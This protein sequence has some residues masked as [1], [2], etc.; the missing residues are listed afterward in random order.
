MAGGSLRYLQPTEPAP[1]VPLG[2]PAQCGERGGDTRTKDSLLGEV[3]APEEAQNL[4][5]EL[6]FPVRAGT[7]RQSWNLPSDLE[8]PFRARKSFQ[9]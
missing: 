3:E 2:L 5:S 6:E 7:S 8:P 9:S 1:K 4:Q